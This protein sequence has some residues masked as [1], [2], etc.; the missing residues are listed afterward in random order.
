M[1]LSGLPD[2]ARSGRARPA[3]ARGCPPRAGRHQRPW[4]RGAAPGPLLGRGGGGGGRGCGVAARHA[5]VG[6]SVLSVPTVETCLSS[7]G[8]CLEASTNWANSSS[9]SA[10]L[11]RRSTASSTTVSEHSTL[12]LKL[13]RGQG[14]GSWGLEAGGRAP[15]GGGGCEAAAE[16]GHS[17]GHRGGEVP[18]LL[19]LGGGM[20]RHGGG[21]EWLVVT[22]D[23]PSHSPHNQRDDIPE[24]YY[25]LEV[26]QYSSPL[27]CDYVYNTLYY[28][29][30]RELRQ[31]GFWYFG[32]LF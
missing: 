1:H 20:Q 6:L 25:L 4:R 27:H 2:Q 5:R 30:L 12:H 21:G 3:A 22:R 8:G 24:H 13:G 32:N 28:I 17:E 10:R 29:A 23:C 11:S 9:C 26:L 16:G 7:L 31:K 18:V 15:G 14:P 19:Q